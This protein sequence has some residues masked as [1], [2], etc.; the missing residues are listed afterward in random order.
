MAMA[1]GFDFDKA[2]WQREPAHDWVNGGVVLEAWKTNNGFLVWI[3]GDLVTN[4]EDGG[5]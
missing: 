5:N 1:E 3:K 2:G 4:P